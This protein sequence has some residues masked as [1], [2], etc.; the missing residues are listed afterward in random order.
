MRQKYFVAVLATGALALVV[1]AFAVGSSPSARAT[2][3]VAFDRVV[4]DPSIVPNGHKPKAIG[5][6]DGDGFNDIFAYSAGQG[7]FWYRYP[8]WTKFKISDGGDGE[9]AQAA[10]V[11]G[12][13][14]VDVLVGGIN[15]PA[16]WYENPRMEGKDPA[17]STWVEHVIGGSQTHDLEVGDVNGDQKVDVATQDG[18]FVQSTPTSWTLIDNSH[19]P[20]RAGAG[21]SLGDINGDGSID[22]VDA[23]NR[24]LV[25]YE[26]PRGSGRPLTD[27]WT[28]RVIGAGFDADSIRVADLNHDGRADVLLANEY[29]SGGLQWFEGPANPRRQSWAAHMIDSTVNNVH[30]SSIMVGD[31]DGDKTPDVA[32]AEQE[33]SPTK[34]V[35]VYYNTAGDATAWSQQVLATTGGHNPKMGDI[36]NDGRLDILNANHGYFGAANPI[37]LFRNAGSDSTTTLPPTSTT[38]Q[39]GRGRGAH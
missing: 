24:Q 20:G 39:H 38:P 33:Q 30:Q 31:F 4:I 32:I 17:T 15:L 26:N 22:L 21:T 35:A 34:R 2:G 29:G 18:V 19:F 13:G 8:S 16:R 14:A 28:R 12:D 10:D 25:W 37:E 1:G 23:S 11:N 7:L 27:V 36:G 5:D 3:N 9:Q 6:V